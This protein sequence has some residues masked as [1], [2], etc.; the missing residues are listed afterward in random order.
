MCFLDSTFK[1]PGKLQHY[2]F[3]RTYVSDIVISTFLYD[4]VF[5]LHENVTAFFIDEVAEAEI[6]KK[7]T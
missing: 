5:C 6:S 3:S 7:L 4:L 2:N 1:G